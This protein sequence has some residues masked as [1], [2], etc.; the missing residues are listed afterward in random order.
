VRYLRALLCL[1]SGRSLFLVVACVSLFPGFVRGS[2]LLIGGYMRMWSIM[3]SANLQTYS[4]TT[5]ENVSD[6]K[7]RRG[8]E[9][10]RS[11][12]KPPV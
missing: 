6:G 7:V 3:L 8:E 12:R 11:C 10:E 9:D 1:S 4:C 2:A 5:T